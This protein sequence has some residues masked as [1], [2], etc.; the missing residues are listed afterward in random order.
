MLGKARLSSQDSKREAV[1][2]EDQAR[3]SMVWGQ[4]PEQ[5]TYNPVNL[6]FCPKDGIAHG[7]HQSLVATLLLK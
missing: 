5:S 2:E 3:S 1:M 4:T 7:Y 6:R